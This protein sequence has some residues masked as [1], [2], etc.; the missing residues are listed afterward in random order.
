MHGYWG[1]AGSRQ[2]GASVAQLWSQ[3]VLTRT[4]DTTFKASTG[5]VIRVSLEQNGTQGLD[6]KEDDL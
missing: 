1:E 4:R 5:N 3:E 2:I 6:G